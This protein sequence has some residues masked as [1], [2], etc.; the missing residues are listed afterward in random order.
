MEAVPILLVALHVHVTL[1]S[2][3]ME[4][5]AVTSMNVTIVHAAAMA[6]AR[7]QSVH[8]LA[9]A[10]MVSKETDLTALILM[11]VQL[12]PITVMTM[13]P[14]KT[15]LDDSLADATTDIPVME[16]TAMMSTNVTLVY[17]VPTLLGRLP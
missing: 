9:H 13:L 2:L 12:I 3:V 11:N 10:M 7:T 17:V 6:H 5:L 15:K 1:A 16:L 4:L 14:V 8:S